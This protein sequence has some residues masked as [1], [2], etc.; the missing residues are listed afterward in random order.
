MYLCLLEIQHSCPL[1]IYIITAAL[2][3]SML[4]CYAMIVLYEY[5]FLSLIHFLTNLQWRKNRE[6]KNSFLE[7]L[8]YVSIIGLGEKWILQWCWE[9]MAI[10][11]MSS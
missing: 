1:I 3:P 8:F 5:F 9:P 10:T 2:T 6:M 4:V 7:K 11:D